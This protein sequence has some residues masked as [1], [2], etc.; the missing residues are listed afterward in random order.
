MVITIAE[1]KSKA[2]VNQRQKLQNWCD[3]SW[4]DVY[5]YVYYRVQNREEAEDV[6]QETY[7][8]ALK[9]FASRG[10]LPSQGYLKTIALNLIRDRWR[11]QQVQGVTV[12]LEDV[13]L[14]RESDEE[15]A[16][17][18]NVI[19]ILMEQLSEEQRT[20]LQLRIIEGY[21]RAETALRMGK[22]EDAVRGLQY[23][24]VQAL[25]SLMVKHSEEVNK[26]D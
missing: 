7:A 21:S 1:S 10:K 3:N 17:N 24:A 11:R 4:P 22:S 5:R 15:A 23:R 6:T 12:S 8:R 16:V 9:K 2:T 14:L 13:F 20:V 19:R 25:R 18:R 26:H